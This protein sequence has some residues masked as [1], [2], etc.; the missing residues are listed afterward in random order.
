MLQKSIPQT[1][2]ELVPLAELE[3]RLP[4]PYLQ[5]VF[6]AFLASRFVYTA[7]DE[8]AAELALHQFLNKLRAEYK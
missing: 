5:A 3:R 2:Q 6:A 1:L 8:S 4:K 7:E